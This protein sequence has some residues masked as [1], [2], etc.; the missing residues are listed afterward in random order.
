MKEVVLVQ[1]IVIV[2]GTTTNILNMMAYMLGDAYDENEVESLFGL[3]TLLIK[4]MYSTNTTVMWGIPKK[5]PNITEERLRSY[6]TYHPYL[7]TRNINEETARFFDIGFDSI[8]NQITFP[9]YNIKHICIGIGRRSIE[10]KQY[11]YPR[12]MQKPLYGIYELPKLVRTI[13]VVEGPFNLWSLKQWGKY[14]VALLG[15]GTE[16]Q[17]KDLTYLNVENYVLALDPDDAG[18]NGTYK[19]IKHLIDAKKQNIYI[20]EIPENKDVNDLTLE[21]FNKLNVLNY[22]QWLNKYNKKN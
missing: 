17:Y 1:C 18:R 22:K 6:R 12:D 10:H 9:I 19:I 2:V 4:D 11:I 15:T 13:F 7:K 16:K 8:T 21:E 5:N 14:G 3:K 20:V